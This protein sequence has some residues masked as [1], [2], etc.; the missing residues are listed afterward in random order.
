M[1]GIDGWWLDVSDSV[2]LVDTLR[3]LLVFVMNDWYTALVS[4]IKKQDNDNMSINL[5]TMLRKGR[6]KTNT[7]SKSVGFIKC[8]L[9]G[10]VERNHWSKL[11]A[12][13]YSVH[14][15]IEKEMEKLHDYE[16][17]SKSHFS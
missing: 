14:S 12:N 11:V 9:K 1:Y 7:F 5:A 2:Q 6:N 3:S 16:I 15:V 10:D 8:L 17:V 4:I 13:L